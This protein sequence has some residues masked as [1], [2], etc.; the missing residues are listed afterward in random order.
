MTYILSHSE[1]GKTIKQT[2]IISLWSTPR[3]R[4]NLCKSLVSAN[5]CVF[6]AKLKKTTAIT[7]LHN[8]GAELEIH[9]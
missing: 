2:K 4:V 5:F 8:A 7:N 1:I 9:L 6:A 3:T